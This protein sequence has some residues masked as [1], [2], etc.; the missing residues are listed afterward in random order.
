MSQSKPVSI[1][2]LWLFVALAAWNSRDSP[3]SASQVLGSKGVCLVLA[4][5][6]FKIDSVMRMSVLSVRILY[7]VYVPGVAEVNKTCW[8]S[9][10]SARTTS[11]LNP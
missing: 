9:A 2:A 7:H 10:S 1:A 8:D 6:N 5:I 4:A 3:A 11:A